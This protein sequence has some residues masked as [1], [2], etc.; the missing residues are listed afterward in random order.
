MKKWGIIEENR[1]MENYC[2]NRICN[3]WRRCMLPWRTCA[4]YLCRNQRRSPSA[5]GC[6]FRHGI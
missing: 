2:R 1:D 6:N 3:H 5:F 4:E